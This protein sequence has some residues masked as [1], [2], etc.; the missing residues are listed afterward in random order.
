MSIY[1]MKLDE[2]KEYAMQ[3]KI[4]IGKARTKTA[5]IRIIEQSQEQPQESSTVALYADHNLFHPK[6]GTIKKGYNVFDHETADLWLKAAG[7]RLKVATPQ[8]VAAFYGV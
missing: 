4:D 2:L 6:L 8:E 5:I 3:N 1:D 7:N